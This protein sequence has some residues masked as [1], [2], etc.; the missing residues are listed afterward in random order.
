MTSSWSVEACEALPARVR[1]MGPQG[2]HR[3]P[4]LGARVTAA[5]VPPF[6]TRSVVLVMVGSAPITGLV[7]QELPQSVR[8]DV[9]SDHRLDSA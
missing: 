4:M 2:A 3:T 8:I 9:P 1:A 7:V 5:A 6:K